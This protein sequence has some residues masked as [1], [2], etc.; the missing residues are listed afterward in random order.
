FNI[1]QEGKRYFVTA[2]HCT[3]VQGGVEQTPFFQSL[4]FGQAGS[5]IGVEERDPAYVGGAPGCPANRVCRG[6][7][8]A[9]IHYNAATPSTL[10]RIARPDG[11]NNNSVR[12]DPANPLFAIAFVAAVTRFTIGAT[13]NKVGRTTGWTQGPV[14]RTCANI[15]VAGSNITLL[16]QTQV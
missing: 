10:S 6:S 16:C 1:Q 5:S 11:T 14:T 7:D 8:A 13:A 4:R 2:S 3:Q 12:I 9:L 15:N